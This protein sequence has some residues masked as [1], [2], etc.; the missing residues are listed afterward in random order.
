MRY[1]LSVILFGLLSGLVQA[2]QA[3]GSPYTYFGVGDINNKG[4]SQ[5]LITGGTGMASRS[6]YTINN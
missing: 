4:L 6:G 3:P 1:S 2:Q 5:Q